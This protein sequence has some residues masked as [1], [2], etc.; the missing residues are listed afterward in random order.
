MNKTT[1]ELIK[2]ANFQYFSDLDRSLAIAQA[3][4]AEAVAALIEAFG[5]FASS[6]LK[7][8]FKLVVQ[9]IHSTKTVITPSLQTK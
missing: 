6:S 9:G 2:Q 7:N 5:K 8:L 3:E 1:V 4:R